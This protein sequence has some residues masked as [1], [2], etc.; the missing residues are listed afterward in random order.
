[1]GADRA[2]RGVRT[3]AESNRDRDGDGTA[4]AL[5]RY[6]DSRDALLTELI[7][8]AYRELAERVEG[9]NDA[10]SQDPIRRLTGIAEAFRRW[11]T[12]HPQR[13]L[14]LYGTPVPG[15]H[16]PDAA[17]ELA[18]RSCAPIVA[19]FELSATGREDLDRSPFQRSMTF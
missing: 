13:Y 10:D 1:M 6:Y 9:A 16:A 5:Y 8:S 12:T 3:V 14:L 18:R 11:G 15:Y 7:L 2:G 19:A 17:T 4:P